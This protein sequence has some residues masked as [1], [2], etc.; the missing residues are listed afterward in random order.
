M[1]S[2]GVEDRSRF[3]RKMFER[4]CRCAE[5]FP[6]DIARR[7]PRDVGASATEEEYDDCCADGR[8][9]VSAPRNWS[10]ACSNPQTLSRSR[11]SAPKEF[12]E[13]RMHSIE[14]ENVHQRR[15]ADKAYSLCTE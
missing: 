6:D 10:S 13:R 14:I 12:S 3:A 15:F 1:I 8:G 2:G 11:R 5:C 4:A 7:V 9:A